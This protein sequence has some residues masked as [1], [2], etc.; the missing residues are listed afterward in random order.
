MSRNA[1]CPC[2]SSKKYKV[3]CL[4]HDANACLLGHPSHFSPV[5]IASSFESIQ[6]AQATQ[7]PGRNS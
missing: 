5:N 6:N 7:Q 3:C 1:P 4:K 2:G